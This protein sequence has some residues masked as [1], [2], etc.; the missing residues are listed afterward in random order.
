MSGFLLGFAWCIPFFF[1]LSAPRRLDVIVSIHRNYDL[2]ALGTGRVATLTVLPGFTAT[3]LFPDL[4]T[5]FSRDGTRIRFP[6]TRT[7]V[8]LDDDNFR[9]RFLVTSS[10]LLLAEI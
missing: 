3:R 9:L 10:P 6:R 8:P 2:G 1:S 4:L 5:G 7:L